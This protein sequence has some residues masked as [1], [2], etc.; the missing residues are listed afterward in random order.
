MFLPFDNNHY[1]SYLTERHSVW[2]SWPLRILWHC[3]T[4]LLMTA[5]RC[6]SLYFVHFY[7]W[8]RQL[9]HSIFDS[10]RSYQRYRAPFSTRI[11]A[12]YWNQKMK[13]GKEFI[14]FFCHCFKFKSMATI[15]HKH[16]SRSEMIEFDLKHSVCSWKT[17][18]RRDCISLSN[19]NECHRTQSTKQIYR[20]F[21]FRRESFA[22]CDFLSITSTK[23]LD[24]SGIQMYTLAEW[25]FSRHIGRTFYHSVFLWV[26]R[27][28]ATEL[29]GIC[30][31]LRRA[32][33]HNDR[34]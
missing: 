1:Y 15:H 5:L 6:R 32:R 28:H 26:F 24:V 9:L 10:S 20:W 21:R 29:R 19:S 13:N 25:L 2:C 23:L 14:I 31:V 18:G 27:L 4:S 34:A 22:C 7:R 33:N 16:W 11:T 8:Q 3:V 12:V 30:V 17:V